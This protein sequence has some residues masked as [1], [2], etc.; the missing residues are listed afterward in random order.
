MGAF[1]GAAWI[2][3]DAELEVSEGRVQA[4]KNS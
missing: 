1:C 2:R 4:H 3:P